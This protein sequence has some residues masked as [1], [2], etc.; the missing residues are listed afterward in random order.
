MRIL[1]H[2]DWIRC[3]WWREEYVD[4]DECGWTLVFLRCEDCRKRFKVSH[5][6]AQ[7]RPDHRQTDAVAARLRAELERNVMKGKRALWAR[8][9]EL[10]LH[11][12]THELCMEALHEVK[13]KRARL[14][15]SSN[16]AYRDHED[17]EAELA[18]E[19]GA[20]R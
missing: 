11:R 15:D 5:R 3:R 8:E 1:T 12:M 2:W 16:D 14:E 17:M 9:E 13:A 20:A 18:R 6:S 19:Y 4:G 10:E 7:E